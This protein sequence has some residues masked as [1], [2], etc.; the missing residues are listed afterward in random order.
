M[1]AKRIG[2]VFALAL[3]LTASFIAGYFTTKRYV[4]NNANAKNQIENE[5][6]ENTVKLP[7]LDVIGPS[8]EIVFRERYT[9]GVEYNRDVVEKASS[10]VVGM[11]REEA[12]E[13]FK[14]KGYS[15]VDFDN[16]RVLVVKDIQD[17]WPVGC[18]VVKEQDGYIAIF[19]VN[20]NGELKLY[21]L[22][23]LKISDIPDTDK[24]EVIKGKVYETIEDALELIEEYT[25]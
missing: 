22:T 21:R 16:R 17:K 8:T 24:E 13:Y 19:E 11:K 15:I 12:A 1:I 18:Y 23:E 10:E 9:I 4:E 3:S 5:I 2:L 20:S 7:D 6:A 25:S 14:L